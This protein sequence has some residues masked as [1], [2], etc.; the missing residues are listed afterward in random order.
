MKTGRAEELLN[1]LRLVAAG[2]TA[3]DARHPRRPPGLAA[4]SPRE[5]EVLK[6]MAAGATNKEIAEKLGVGAETVK[7]LVGRTFTKLGVGKRAEAV[8]V[9]HE[10]GIL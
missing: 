10:L 7:T 8:A 6:L 1:A 9:A 4:L 5:R 3:Y 2:G